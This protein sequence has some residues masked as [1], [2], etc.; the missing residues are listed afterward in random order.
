MSTEP[1]VGARVICK[2]CGNE[3][4]PGPVCSVCNRPLPRSI[5]SNRIVVLLAVATA[6]VA[7]GVLLAALGANGT[8]PS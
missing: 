3:T 6:I 5:R 2:Q 4:P 7:L 8:A 1:G